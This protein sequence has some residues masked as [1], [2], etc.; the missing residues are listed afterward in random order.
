MPWSGHSGVYAA[1]Q[2]I[3]IVAANRMTLIFL[4]YAQP[5]RADLPGALV[6]NDANLPIGIHHGSPQ[7]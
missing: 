5:G 4:Q 7:P 6:E 3:E 2:V 1:K